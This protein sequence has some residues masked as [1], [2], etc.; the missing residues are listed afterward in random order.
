MKVKGWGDVHP[1]GVFLTWYR[2]HSA[3]NTAAIA[4]ST[5]LQ[6]IEH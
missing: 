2:P 6:K 5:G 4:S 1:K 3:E